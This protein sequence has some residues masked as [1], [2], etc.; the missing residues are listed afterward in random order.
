LLGNLK[1]AISSYKNA[2]EFAVRLQQRTAEARLLGRIGAVYADV[3]ELENSNDYLQ[4]S[5]SLSKR[6]EEHQL[7]A[8]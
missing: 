3:G 4:R 8:E 2:L 7:T 5:M 1:G 6:I